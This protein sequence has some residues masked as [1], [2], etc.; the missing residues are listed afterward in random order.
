MIY[1]LLFWIITTIIATLRWTNA[2]LDKHGE[3]DLF[4]IIAFFTFSLLLAW[5]AIFIVSSKIKIKRKKKDSE[6]NNYIR[7]K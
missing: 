7:K 6:E 1:F 2:E 3:V 4:T 5:V